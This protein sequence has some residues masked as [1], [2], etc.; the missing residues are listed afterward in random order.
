MTKVKI[1]PKVM[2]TGHR[3]TAFTAD[4]AQWAK[5]QI[6][7]T[8]KRLKKFHG[9]QEA[10]SGMALGVDTWWAQSALSL[11]FELA[12]YV[13]FEAQSKDW[14]EEET[15]EWLRLRGLAKREVILSDSYSVRMFHARNDA[16]LRDSDL[17]VGV[18]KSDTTR[19]GS[20][21]TVAK[22]RKQNKPLIL[23]DPKLLTLTTENLEQ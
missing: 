18:L 12:S 11:D 19:G 6:H 16:M 20:Y 17:T 4:E 21:S 14:T 2:V 23:I 10:I 5:D 9:A 13:P 1:F 15:L 3:P 7:T 8:L 22:A